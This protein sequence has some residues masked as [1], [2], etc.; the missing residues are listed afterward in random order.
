M[1]EHALNTLVPKAWGQCRL[2]F[3]RPGGSARG[4]WDQ[5]LAESRSFL[6]IPSLGALVEGWLLIVPKSHC[7][8][9]AAVPIQLMDELDAL[10]RAVC[11][12]LRDEFG[13][14]WTFEHGPAAEKRTCGCGV[15]HAHLHAVPLAFDLIKRAKPFLP[16]EVDFQPGTLTD[17]R[18]AASRGLDY[19]YAEKWGSALGSIACSEEIG[20]QV[21]RRAVASHQHMVEQYNWR[22]HQ[23]L[24]TVEKTIRRMKNRLSDAFP[25]DHHV[26]I[27]AA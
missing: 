20:S 7:V 21:F 15:D 16:A 19:L 25:R 10:K 4:P 11:E 17:C 6:V 24:E 22:E 12:S 26:A 23:H 2:C 14:V 27:S 13:E 8:S 3:D 1:I 18:A 9:F 5:S